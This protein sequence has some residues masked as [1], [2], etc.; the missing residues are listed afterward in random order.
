MSFSRLPNP[1]LGYRALHPLSLAQQKN[2]SQF[3]LFRHVNYFSSFAVL[4]DEFRLEP[5]NTRV[6][7]GDTALLECAS[8]KGQ[9]EPIVFWKK[10]GQKLDIEHSKRIRIVDGGNL[11][12]QDARQ[13]DEG[14]YQCIAK[15]IVGIRESAPAF[16]KVHGNFESIRWMLKCS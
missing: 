1:P 15:N 14:Q 11:A 6:A 3:E 4:R 8:P 13:G 12:I 9:P 10:N 7:Q 5:Q 2:G 16:L